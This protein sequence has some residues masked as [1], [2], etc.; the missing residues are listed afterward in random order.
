[1]NDEALLPGRAPGPAAQ[2]EVML[3]GDLPRHTLSDVTREFPPTPAPPDVRVLGH[4]DVLE[5]IGRG[6]FG[7]VV[8]AFD[9]K[10]Q[11]I[12]AIK[13]MSAEMAATSP[14]RKRFVREARAAAAVRH[15]NV[16]HIYTV[17]EQ[18]RPYLVME[19][20]PGGSLQQHLDRVG[21][22]EVAEVL[23]LGGQLARGLAAAHATGLVHRDVK[24][25]NVLLEPG[26]PPQAKLTDFGIALAADD[27]S[28]TQ[29]G[30]V[31]GTPMYM[32]PEQA[33]GERVDHRADLFSLGSVLY[34]MVCGRPPFRATNSLAVLKRVAE[35][36]PRPVEE[37]M[38]G[39]P[40]WLSDVI[41]KLHA[42]NP[43]NRFQ[44]AA[45]V[46]AILESCQAALELGRPIRPA[47]GTRGRATWK[48]SIGAVSAFAC[49]ALVAVAAFLPSTPGN[50]PPTGPGTTPTTPTPEPV[51]PPAADPKPDRYTNAVGIEFVRVPAGKSKLGGTGGAAGR[52][53]EVRYDFYMGK[54]EVTREEWE[55][56]M[57]PRTDPSR[58][59]RTGEH[60]AAV[61]AVP[62]AD[63]K[64]FPVDG[65][66]WNDCQDF[67]RRLNQKVKETGWV[68]RLPTTTEWEYACRNGPG[69]PDAA[70]GC[71]YYA[72]EPATTLRPDQA[73]LLEAGLNRP[74]RVG[75][76]A[77]NR[78]GLHDLHGNVFE[79]LDDL[80]GE[81][82]DGRLLAGGFWS[83]PPFHSSRARER[84]CANPEH[85]L[86][87]GGLRLVRVPA[88]NATTPRQQFEAFAADLRRA[89]PD[90]KAILRPV[91]ANDRITELFVTDARGITDISPLRQL[92]DLH[93]LNAP[94]GQF[95][96][97]SP[98]SGLPLR[99]L[100]IDNNWILRDLSPLKGMRIEWMALWG[101]QGN[102]LSPLEGMPLKYLN[103]GG[104]Q[105]KL[106]LSPLRGMPLRGLCLN[107]TLVD[108][109]TPLTGLPLDE[110]LIQETLVRDL[111]PLRGMKL[112]KLC[113]AG[114]GVTD[115]GALRGM[116]LVELSCNFDPSRDADIIRDFPALDLI[117]GKS[118]IE[119]WN[120]VEK[121]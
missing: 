10:L 50:P 104:G 25:A 64:R 55:A 4:F 70:L 16:V 35:G 48:R 47:G 107:C 38:P 6:G 115:L 62:D 106:D 24:P 18:P 112:R 42:R 22:L 31:M 33:N 36:T 116:P 57:G 120:E 76:Y 71:D 95:S 110:L 98:L 5:T 100:A 2:T 91:F 39:T 53:V 105:R 34:T 1:M 90:F 87:G 101:F 26:N 67:L 102:D 11:R 44:S 121:K 46:A 3:R 77:P 58:Y 108:D 61:A 59:S 37:V 68:Y 111:T 30:V 65:V 103:C 54:Y 119:F 9:R 86:N 69:Q 82:R 41:A 63:F 52:E 114:S 21:P 94:H 88:E 96:D 80:G 109:L 49:V 84:G 17:E 78:L 32:A 15:E 13:L 19:Y 99:C 79:F 74:C 75:S 118:P 117:N 60:A 113:G 12:V 29:S 81:N 40:R 20:V 93:N 66:A 23:R 51:P 7:V 27:A 89:N 8:K 72:G 83:D 28:L 73:N 14:A 92:R 56:V 43:A 85:R 97:L 45:E